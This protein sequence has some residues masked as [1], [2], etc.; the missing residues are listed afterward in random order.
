MGC[1]KAETVEFPTKRSA[2][3]LENAAEGSHQER[4]Q[5]IPNA[6]LVRSRDTT[7]GDNNGESYRQISKRWIIYRLDDV[8]IISIYVYVA[9]WVRCC[10]A[11]AALD[12]NESHQF[13]GIHLRLGS[14]GL[15]QESDRSHM[16]LGRDST[17]RDWLGFNEQY[18]DDSSLK[19][20]M[21]SFIMSQ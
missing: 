14:F 10:R 13:H 8:R 1:K 17:W 21:L 18:W 11:I 3:S 20:S 6:L 16:Q 9:T 4:L 12:A 5:R 15:W 19:T 7:W 2:K